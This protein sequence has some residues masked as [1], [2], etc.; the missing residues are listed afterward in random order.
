[1]IGDTAQTG[2]MLARLAGLTPVTGVMSIDSVTD[3]VVCTTREEG[4]TETRLP[5]LL[6]IERINSL[7][8][9]RLRSKLGEV[10]IWRA[11]DL[12]ADVSKC[13]LSG[14]PTRVVKTFENEGGKRK[15]KFITRSELDGVIESALLKSKES[16]NYE[17]KPKNSTLV[18][19]Y[20]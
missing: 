14:S 9:P 18:R 7:R 13:G 16:I 4:R 1:M 20:L 11:S 17:K 2:V 5:A 3:T 10:E 8:L 6:T 19:S 12:D 15:C